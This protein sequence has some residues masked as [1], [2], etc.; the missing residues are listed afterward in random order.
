MADVVVFI[1]MLALYS[2]VMVYIGYRGYK[3][4]KNVQDWLVAGRRVGPLVVA[5]SYGATFIS[6]VAIIGF[7]GQAQLFG[8]QLLWL[9]VLNIIVGILIA[10]IV[11][12]NRTRIMSKTLQALTFTE[13]LAKRFDSRFVQGF[14]GA[15]IA[16]FLIAYSAAVF[17]GTASLIQ[18]TF[19]T[20]YTTAIVVFTVIVAVYVLLGGLF[21]V[22][23]TDTVQ[24]FIMLF[25]LAILLAIVWMQLGGPI[26]A[27]EALAALGPAK[28]APNGL[29]SVSPFGST[30]FMLVSSLIFGVGIG[31][32]AQPQ[33][34]VRFM[35][36]KNTRAIRRGIPIGVIFIFLTTYVAFT[37]GALS[38]VVFKNNGVVPP[39]NPDLV[40]PTLINLAFPAWFVYLFLF[41]ILSA[42]MSTAS[43]L[44]HV[45]G[46]AVGRD[47][48][49]KAIKKGLAGAASITV[50]KVATF[51]VIALTLLLALFPPDA[52]AYLAT[53]S[54]GALGAT[55][56]APFSATL[57]WKRATTLGIIASM[58]GGLGSTL[59]WYVFVYQKT[60]TVI[61]HVNV[62]APLGLLDPLFI[63]IPVSFAL[64]IIVSLMTK[65]PEE[66]HIARAFTGI[67]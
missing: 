3:A 39:T 41:A 50:T 61:S 4:T 2:A 28:M 55:F 1:V 10:F 27:N 48:Y 32:L 42:S 14:G 16:I 49:D 37:V 56:I 47:I 17:K 63:G 7:G 64:V 34:A 12:G 11:F 45:S 40:I 52:V 35:S 31:V 22:L 43:S 15:V 18:Q 58:V 25:G 33:L 6:A 38:N 20:S 53:F 65:Q 24:G 44:F 36:A 8:L 29:T 62:A 23:W 51:V 21:A 30:S 5:M 19:G 54:F 13:L 57:Y 9:S 59:L 60:A 66:E 26:A 46:S 67:S